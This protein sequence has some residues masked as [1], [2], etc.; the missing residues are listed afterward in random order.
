M[1][2]YIPVL[3]LLA[4][5]CGCRSF[6][7]EELAKAREIARDTFPDLYERYR[8]TPAEYISKRF[9][10]LK[11]LC[12]SVREPEVWPQRYQTAVPALASFYDELHKA[13]GWSLP[14][15]VTVPQL[16][17]IPVIDG[18]ITRD[19][20]NL[21]KVFQGEY[22]LDEQT[23]DK[24]NTNTRWYLGVG[25]EAFYIAFCCK[26]TDIIP[27]TM[28]NEIFSGKEKNPVYEGDALEFFIRPDRQ[29]PYYIE[30]QVN[31]D[32]LIWPLRHKLAPVDGW[33]VVDSK[34]R[35]HGVSAVSSRTADGYQIEM[36]VPFTLLPELDLNNFTFML[37]RTHRDFSGK[38]WS[39][40]VCPLIYNAHNV[41]GFIP[42]NTGE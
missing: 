15:K 21:A 16:K 19:E 9:Y 36:R 22:I 28:T 7:P 10:K 24:N 2:K 42:A 12:W 33:Q 29:K 17:K 11:D 26:D 18:K 20:W 31:A 41:Y 30:I 13:D 27:F 39:S 37:L 32:A 38:N 14:G 25:K 34:I 4:V 40:A 1:R 3:L 6:T 23:P 35:N 8:G 5:L